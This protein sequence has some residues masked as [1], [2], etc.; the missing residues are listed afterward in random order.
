M[1]HSPRFYL[2]RL[3][4]VLLAGA[5][6][7]ATSGAISA[8]GVTNGATFQS[9][10]VAPGE[11]VTIFGQG[12][13]P[14]ALAVAAYD[15]NGKLPTTAGDTQVLFDGVPAPI[16]YALNGQ[17]SAIVPY[18]VSVSTQVQIQYQ[19]AA[20]PAVSVPVVKSAPGVFQC[21]N[22]AGVAV[23]IN[24]TAGNSVSCNDDF[25]PPGPGSVLTV[26]LTGVGAAAPAIAD[27]Q[28]PSSPLPAPAQPWTVSIGGVA[29]VPCAATFAGLI[30]AGVA[31]V[32]LCVPDGVPRTASVPFTVSIGGTASAPAA[33]NLQQSWH[34]IWSD[35]FNAPA[36]TP[37]D[38]TK[39][40]FDLGRGD[41]GWGNNELESYTDS[42]DN[43]SQDGNGNLMIRALQTGSGSYTSGRIK[44]QDKFAVQYGKVE[45]RI[46]IPY[47]QGIWP[48]FWMLGSNIVSAGWP[49]AGE[50]DIMENIGREPSIVH[51]TVHG[52]GYSG[53][54]GI[55][56]PL[57]LTNGQRFSDDFHIYSVEWS[58]QSVAFLVDGSKYFEVTPS[59]LPAG[60]TWVYQHPF[61]ILLNV[62]VG[63]GWPGYPDA[64]TVFPQQ[65]LVDW[66][67]VSQLM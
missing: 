26:F 50:I 55:G 59:K 61:F 3:V 19:G 56:G 1:T 62:A 57:A 58:P 22:K 45:A 34:V 31:Q 13:G 64:T 60:A 38:S 28:Y 23:V 10:P 14:P 9:G 18:S 37:V 48:A 46:K 6:Q 25:V 30:Y 32:N 42:T 27:G 4:V 43:V 12:F 8:N 44:T 17:V 51:G 29:A 2:I 11:I 66:V 41:N 47:G 53:A 39:W 54:N 49:T 67:R 40:G 15:S 65:M 21:S 16:I 63:G 7:A 24:A 33:L 35:E 36:G 52:P 5:A 20:T